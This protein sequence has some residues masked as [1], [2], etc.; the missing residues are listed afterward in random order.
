MHYFQCKSTFIVNLVKM[1]QNK[2]NGKVK[3]VILS[4]LVFD[5]KWVLLTQFFFLYKTSSAG[6][7]KLCIYTRDKIMMF[8]V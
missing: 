3:I 8:P 4:F 6:F 7:D 2:I 5:M 1:M